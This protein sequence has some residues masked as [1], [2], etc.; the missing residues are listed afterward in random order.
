MNSIFG[1][2]GVYSDDTCANWGGGFFCGRFRQGFFL[3]LA[4][5]LIKKKKNNPALFGKF[6]R[7]PPFSR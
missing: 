1:K 5:Y 7:D 2:P 6:H 4:W 3:E